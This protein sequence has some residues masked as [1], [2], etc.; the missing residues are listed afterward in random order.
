MSA[1]PG[2]RAGRRVAVVAACSFPSPR[3]SQVLVRSV[4]EQLAASGHEVHLVTY[5]SPARYAAPAG[6]RWHPTR[7]SVGAPERPGLRWS[8]LLQNLALLV[9]LGRV[10]R[11]ERIEV[12]HAHNYEAPL[13]AFAVRLLCRVPVVYH[14]HNALSDELATYVA[15]GWRRRLAT[16]VGRVLDRQIPRRADF[17]IALTPELAAFLAGCGVRS[18]RLAVIAPTAMPAA[19]PQPAGAQRRDRFALVYAG[20]L[21]PYQDLDVLAEAF[22]RL[23]R[24][25]ASAHLT[26][27][28][29]EADW[30]RRLDPRFTGWIAAGAAAVHVEA[31]YAAV[32]RRM[33]AADVLVCPRSSWS[34]YPIKLLNYASAGRP[35]IV[36]RGSAK[37][38]RDEDS[39]LVVADRDPDAIVAAA[40]RLRRDP[41]LASRLGAAAHRLAL[42]AFASAEEIA[43]KFEMIYGKIA[44][45][46]ET[47]R[48]GACVCG[49]RSEDV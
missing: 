4:A 26:V 48:G 32:W 40:L 2:I 33:A 12:I 49:R 17:A 5:G 34:G 19:P 31:D 15:A 45:R 43:F 20:N 3:G 22:A 18:G 23:R 10:V 39:A 41:Q 28:T 29:H 27:V 21:D 8:K 1:E 9:E 44:P 16:W 14:A 35:I 46:Y 38:L 25:T 6:I 24:L 36:A 30:R 13:L 47:S 11:R 37:G 42:Q 7:W